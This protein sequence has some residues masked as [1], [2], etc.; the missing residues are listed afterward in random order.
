MRLSQAQKIV[1][2]HAAKLEKENQRRRDREWDRQQERFEN[3]V[4]CGFCK[5]TTKQLR[6]KKAKSCVAK[7]WLLLSETI[8]IAMCE[9][10]AKTV[11]A[12]QVCE[13]CWD[14][15]LSRIPEDQEDE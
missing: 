15:A 10:E 11:K 12:V 1:A 6:K 13:F 9:D 7:G 5:I 4:R 3:T 14:K 8:P 2:K